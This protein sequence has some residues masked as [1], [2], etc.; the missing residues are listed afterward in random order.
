MPQDFL[1]MMAGFGFA[2]A[3]GLN[4]WLTLLLVSIASK[5]GFLTLA[6]PY[7][8]MSSPPIMI[9]L[10]AMTLI[11][12]LADKIPGV[13]HASHIIHLV[14]QPVAGAILFASQAGI[15]T[16]MSPVLAF[17]VGALV[18]GTV[19]AVRATVRPVVTVSTMGVGNPVVSVAEDVAAGTITVAAIAAPV[20]AVVAIIMVMGAAVWLWDSRRS[21][22]RNT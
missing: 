12:G 11:E 18:A 16:D 7:D 2:T 15:I 13:D 9:F 6:Q 21:A 22:R 5:L 8:V 19:H 3:A 20:L 17:M 10:V 14:L 4:A 1:A